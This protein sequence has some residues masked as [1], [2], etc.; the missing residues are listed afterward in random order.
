VIALCRRSG[1]EGELM[2]EHHDLNGEIVGPNAA[3]PDDNFRHDCW[4]YASRPS[5]TA[6]L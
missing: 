2:A 4:P 6:S 5:A 3:R 1:K